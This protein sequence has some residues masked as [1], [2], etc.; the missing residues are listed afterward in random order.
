MGLPVGDDL[1]QF[2]VGLGGGGSGYEIP[3]PGGEK[4]SLGSVALAFRPVTVGAT[5]L[6]KALSALEVIRVGGQHQTRR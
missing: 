5:F 6:V 4:G 2:L 3:R 1:Q